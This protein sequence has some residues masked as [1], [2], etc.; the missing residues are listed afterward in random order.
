VPRRRFQKGNIRVRGKIPTRYGMYREDV[1][2]PDGT[3][4]RMRRCVTLGPVSK[5]SERAA[6]KLFQPYLDRVNAACKMPQK[7]GKTLEEFVQE[8]R[9]SVAVNLKG[10]TARA[11][12]SHLRAH[13]L[14]KLGSL[15]LTEVNTKTVQS[16]VA[17]LASGGRTRKT[18]ENVLMTL[19]SLFRTARAWQYA[20]GSWSLKDLTMP[21]EG[22]KKEQR[23][24]TDDETR[25]MIA[26]APEPLSTI[27]AVTAVL[28]LR[29]GETLALRVSD[30]D[31]TRKIVRVRQSVDAATRDVQAVK[32]QASSADLPLPSQL[33][34]RLRTHLQ[35]HEG[36]SDLLFVNRNGRPFSANK[37]REKQLHPLLDALQIPRG[38][39]HSLRHGA[40]S[41]LLADGATPAVVQ[42]QL[43]HSDP[44]ITLGIYGHV[45]GSQQRDAVENR[46]A[47]IVN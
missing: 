24:F 9:T 38:G 29:I 37:L 33:E 44:R 7:A 4:K 19:S 3:F 14:P 41:A 21:R 2:Q 23:S 39:F 34:A 26:S 31:F 10:T 47:R 17:Y 27:L 18:A 40:A 11:A 32:S 16:F 36:E 30:I 46:A 8:W 12:E 42:R 1:L 13:I 43:R 25:K 20:C 28:G 45:V 22:V 5:L 6:W 35:E 15:P